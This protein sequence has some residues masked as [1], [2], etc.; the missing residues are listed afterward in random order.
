MVILQTSPSISSSLSCL[1]LSFISVFPFL[2]FKILLTSLSPTF[3]P[4]LRVDK[5]ERGDHLLTF[6]SWYCYR[7]IILPE[8]VIRDG[9]HRLL[10]L[11]AWVWFFV[12][13]L[14]VILLF[15]K[16]SLLLICFFLFKKTK[17]T[18]KNFDLSQLRL[19]IFV[20]GSELVSSMEESKWLPW[21]FR[22]FLFAR[23]VI[24][25]V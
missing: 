25:H 9:H 14:S 17:K 2:F 4:F 22:S 13:F 6:F 19:I 8:C 18:K 7:S 3:Y 5:V 1:N 16:S 10:F 21:T 24:L 15:C 12:E 23:W 11:I 20:V